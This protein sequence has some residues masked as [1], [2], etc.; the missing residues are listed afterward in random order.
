MK[1]FE[2][3]KVLAVVS[4][5]ATVITCLIVYQKLTDVLGP[6]LNEEQAFVT[7]LPPLLLGIILPAILYLVAEITQIMR[8]YGKHLMN[9]DKPTWVRMK[10]EREWEQ[11]TKQ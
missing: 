8:G 3:F 4:M 1:S 5:V 7:I 11:G 10:E 2:Q 9:D 6:D